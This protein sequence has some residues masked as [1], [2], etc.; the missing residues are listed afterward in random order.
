MHKQT[1]IFKNRYIDSV[2]L[3]SLAA[4]VKKQDGID[5]VVIAM[6]TDMNKAIINQVGL[7][8]PTL[9]QTGVNDLVIGVIAQSDERVSEAFDFIQEQL[10]GK[11]KKNTASTSEKVYSSIDDVLEDGVQPTVALISIPGQFAAREAMQALKN[12]MDVM[13]F[14]DNMTLEEEVA[15]KQYAFEHQRLVMGPDCGTAVLNGVGLCFANEVRRGD[16][17]IVA[18]SGTGSQEVMVQIDR[19]G[20][21]ITDAIGTGGR[22]LSLAVNGL[23]MREGLRRL[24]EDDHTKVIVCVSK[25]PAPQVKALML[26]TCRA[27]AKPIVIC[28]LG[29]KEK[30]EDEGHLHFASSLYEAAYKAVSYSTQPTKPLPPFKTPQIQGLKSI[31]NQFIVGLYCG[32]TLCYEALDQCSPL[33]LIKS[34]LHHNEHASHDVDGLSH[35]LLDLGDDEFTN[36]RP[37]P[38]IEP[39]LRHDWILKAASQETTRVILLDFVLGYGAHPQAVEESIETLKEAFVLAQQRPFDIVAYVCATENDKQG[40][41]SSV[42]ALEAIGVKVAHSN[43][44]ACAMVASMVS[45]GV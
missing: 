29:N 42:Q 34:N 40:L 18:A 1:Q 39:S 24:A 19:L 9:E 37:H 43:L 16:I 4:K 21:G 28:F 25:P 33:G 23:M 32:G 6:A 27:I 45:E 2:S 5:E 36:G 10:S 11:T 44:E 3:M 8:V 20:G 38:M 30:Q 26:E 7:G 22:D 41:E 35:V 13:I 14:S 17:G 15:L 31:P 12:N